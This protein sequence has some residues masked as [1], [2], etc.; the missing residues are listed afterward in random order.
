M[1]P[2]YKKRLFKK[3]IRRETLSGFKQKFKNKWF[4]VVLTLKRFQ[5]FHN[6]L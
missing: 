6:T 1:S 2:I 4:H 3:E 5:H